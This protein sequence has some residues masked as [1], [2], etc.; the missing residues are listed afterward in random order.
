VVAE[1]AAGDQPDL[2]VDL[3]DAGVGQAVAEGG[4]DAGALVADRAGEAD[5]RRQATS[6]GPLQPRR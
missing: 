4:L 5:E 2:G 1:A 3:L 6:A